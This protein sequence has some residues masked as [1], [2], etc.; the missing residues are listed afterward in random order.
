VKALEP[1]RSVPASRV[2]QTL[3]LALAIPLVLV[4]A[5]CAVLAWQVVSLSEHNRWVAH[6]DEV[7][8]STWRL[9]KLLIDQETGLR[10]RLLSGDDAFLQPYVAG[11]AAFPHAV[12]ELRALV[13]D[14]PAQQARIDEVRSRYEAWGRIAEEALARSRAAE[15]V[16][17]PALRAEM[18]ARKAEMDVMRGEIDAILAEE[19][20]LLAERQR[21]ARQMTRRVF[22]W[23][24]AAGLV[25]GI[26]GALF[27]RRLVLSLDDWYAQAFRAQAEALHTSAALA[28]EVTEQLRQA[29]TALLDARRRS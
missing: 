8:A 6:T 3:R 29:E 13:A 11:R 2:H 9:A 20:R 23:G 1:D 28:A 21:T 19:G 22:L 15:V 25:L 17:S 7:I 24:G 14:N 27:M 16:M 4:G 10:A 26:L 5:L 12:D 18:R